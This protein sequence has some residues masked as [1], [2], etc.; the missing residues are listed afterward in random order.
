MMNKN[1]NC[2]ICSF[3][4]HKDIS[5]GGYCTILDKLTSVDT[6]CSL[7]YANMSEKSAIKVLHYFQKWRRGGNF[8]MPNPYVIGVA[9]DAAIR[10]LRKT[11]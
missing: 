11:N 1:T 8:A 2:G 9:V 4:K 3:F 7:D 10:N 6:I 5:G